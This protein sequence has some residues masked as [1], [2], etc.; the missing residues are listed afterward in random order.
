[1]EVQTR[2]GMMISQSKIDSTLAGFC[3]GA[4]PHYVP[5]YD[6]PS[7]RQ[8]S[9]G[10]QK[11]AEQIIANNVLILAVQGYVSEGANC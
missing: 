11:G 9:C 1:M 2:S 8:V 4:D 7:G 10:I 6:S 5:G 3:G